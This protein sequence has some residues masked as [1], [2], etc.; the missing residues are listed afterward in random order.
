V[1][2]CS[3]RASDRLDLIHESRAHGAAGAHYSESAEVIGAFLYEHTETLFRNPDG[4]PR[5][6][7]TTKVDNGA[8]S[9]REMR[10]GGFSRYPRTTKFA[11]P[12]T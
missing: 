5:R 9:A 7:M 8:L 10:P 3:F 12:P 2:L 4:C 1:L 11:V 6:L